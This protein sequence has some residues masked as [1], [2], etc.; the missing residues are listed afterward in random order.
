MIACDWYHVVHQLFWVF[1]FEDSPIP[2]SC[3]RVEFY[4]EAVLKV[5]RNGNQ[6]EDYS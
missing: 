4:P 5:V 6:Y 1:Y 3:A 2:C